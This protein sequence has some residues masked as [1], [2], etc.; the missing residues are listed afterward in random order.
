MARVVYLHQVVC[1]RLH[2]ALALRRRPDLRTR[3]CN[4]FVCA[5]DCKTNAFG[6]WSTCTKSCGTGSMSRSRSQVEPTLGG[7]AC[8]HYAET[9]GCNTHNCPIDCA[10]PAWEAWSTCTTSC[11][12]GSQKRSRV[13][14]E[15]TDGGKACPHSAETR[16]CNTFTYAVDCKTSAFGA[17]RRRRPLAP[18][19][20]VRAPRVALPLLAALAL[21]FS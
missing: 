20:R 19:P 18:A 5:V 15:S 12:T 16:A 8:P 1:R 9:R 2:G 7:K 11:G 17:W 6:A 3:A 13:T 4:T 14:V 21:A 10:V